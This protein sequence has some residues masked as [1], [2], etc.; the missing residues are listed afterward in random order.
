MS[1]A[2]SYAII[3]SLSSCGIEFEVCGTRGRYIYD[4]RH[5]FSEGKFKSC[6][7]TSQCLSITNAP[8]QCPVNQHLLQQRKIASQGDDKLS[9][10]VALL[11]L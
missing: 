4:I 2:T 3:F 8:K 10:G 5:Y 7:E 6:P 1:D 9:M 11:R